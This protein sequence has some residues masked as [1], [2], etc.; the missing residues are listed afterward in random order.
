MIQTMFKNPNNASNKKKKTTR[1][2]P[3][4]KGERPEKSPW[5]GFRFLDRNDY[6]ES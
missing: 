1:D 2:E 4:F 3:H 5:A 6:N